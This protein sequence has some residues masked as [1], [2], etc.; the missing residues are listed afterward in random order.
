M[1]E[2]AI[3]L[4][5]QALDDNTATFRDGQWQAISALVQVPLSL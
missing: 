1:Q 4:L 2:R 3:R 5:R